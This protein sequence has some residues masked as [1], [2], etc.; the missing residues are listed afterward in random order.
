M[1]KA[2]YWEE[3]AR[4]KS[5]KAETLIAVA[6]VAIAFLFHGLASNLFAPEPGSYGGWFLNFAFAPVFLFLYIRI[7]SW[8]NEEPQHL[9][10]DEPLRK[11]T[12]MQADAAPPN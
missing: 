2:E 12:P 9:R 11:I 1:E 10:L 7:G 8:F 4:L 5:N 6:S 3:V